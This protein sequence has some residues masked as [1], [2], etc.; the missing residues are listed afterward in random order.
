MGVFCCLY[1]IEIIKSVLTTIYDK[2]ML[3]LPEQKEDDI[4]TNTKDNQPVLDIESILVETIK[5]PVYTTNNECVDNLA[6][7]MQELHIVE[8]I[9]GNIATRGKIDI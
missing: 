9:L 3:S 4:T 5:V 7:A 1:R 2:A 8:C 6:N